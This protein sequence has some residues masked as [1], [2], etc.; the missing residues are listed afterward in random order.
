MHYK[1]ELKVLDNRKMVKHI[2]LKTFLY[3]QQEGEFKKSSEGEE[4]LVCAIVF[5]LRLECEYGSYVV[6]VRAFT[7]SYGFVGKRWLVLLNLKRG[8]YIKIWK[9]L[10]IGFRIRDEAK[11]LYDAKLMFWFSF[12]LFGQKIALLLALLRERLDQIRLGVLPYP[13]LPL[14]KLVMFWLAWSKILK[15]ETFEGFSHTYS[16]YYKS[17]FG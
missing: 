9:L 14:G 2:N 5:T 17:S 8:F 16:R 11:D 10:M 13:F 6:G 7:L 3:I 4:R 1:N 15:K 12:L